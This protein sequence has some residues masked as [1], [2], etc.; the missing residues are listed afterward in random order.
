MVA[1]HTLT[2]RTWTASARQST[3][4]RPARRA[5]TLV[6]LLV[7]ITIIA[8]LIG[9]LI[10]TLG[11]IIVRSS[12]FRLQSEIE[13]LAAACE[14]FKDEFGFYPPDMREFYNPATNLAYGYSDDIDPGPGVVIASDRLLQILNTGWPNHQEN[15]DDPI[16]PG[17]F[18]TDLGSK[19]RLQIWYETIGTALAN[20]RPGVYGCTGH[21]TA[22]WYWLSQTFNDAQ[23]PLSGRRDTTTPDPYQLAA[24]VERKV[25]F[26]F[27][28]DRLHSPIDQNTG[29]P[30]QGFFAFYP[31]P[32]DTTADGTYLLYHY[33]Q[34][35][36]EEHPYVYFHSSS[37]GL[38]WE[39]LKPPQEEE[40]TD[41][42][43]DGDFVGVYI[44]PTTTPPSAYNFTSFQIIAAGSDGDYGLISGAEPTA[45][46]DPTLAEDADNITNFSEGRIETMKAAQ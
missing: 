24:G 20:G 2:S 8:I 15:T 9:L 25:L 14:K 28:H 12:D 39:P 16:D 41:L 26:D 40:T 31:D 6:E 1:H 27:D 46:K 38:T 34:D 42:Q 17:V 18:P 10:V 36:Y 30:M 43:N 23:F 11:P 13:Q 19:S 35:G 44:D 4:T 45:G 21:E 37:Y 32:N 29:T 5:F 22:L 3:A 33:E 7:V